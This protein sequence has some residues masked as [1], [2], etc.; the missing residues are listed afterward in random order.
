MRTPIV[1][2]KRTDP[3]RPEAATIAIPISFL[4]GV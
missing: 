4:Q 1:A 2:A 3:I